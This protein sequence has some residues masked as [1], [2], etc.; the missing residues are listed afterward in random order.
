MFFAELVQN[1]TEAIA[2]TL[3][4]ETARYYEKMLRLHV[5]PEF[6]SVQVAAITRHD[7]SRFLAGKAPQG[8][9]RSSMKGMLTSLSTV[10]EY[11]V[12]CD[13]LDKNPCKGVKIPQPLKTARKRRILSL[14]E[15]TQIAGKLSEPYATLF[16][17]LGITGLRIGEACGVKWSAIDARGVLHVHQKVYEGK[18]GSLKTKSSE[19]SLPLP[20]ALLARMRTLEQGEWVFSSRTGT[21]INAGNALKRHIHPAAKSLGID[22]TG[23]HDLRHSATTRMIR[24]GHSPKTVSQ[25]LGHSNLNITL[26]I[27]DHPE[28]ED[29]RAPLSGMADQ[30]LRDVMKS[31]AGT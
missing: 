31:E 28:L 21:P 1:W 14:E 20:A 16:A 17:F 2:P 12:D 18:V 11:A 25:I 3:K 4:S 6:G 22:L 8:Y 9:S 24:D 19:R 7:V 15:A 23:W 10:L 29:F 26:G 30:L 5:A 13:V 27:Y